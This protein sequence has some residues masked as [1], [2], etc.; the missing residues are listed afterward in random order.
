MMIDAIINTVLQ[1]LETI[2]AAVLMLLPDSPFQSITL[3]NLGVLSDVMGYINY[4]IPMAQILGFI[5]LYI[6]AIVIW[7]S[8][9]WILRIARYID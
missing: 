9:R 5:S 1:T 4:F 3:D 6:S 8:V 2:A 7:Y